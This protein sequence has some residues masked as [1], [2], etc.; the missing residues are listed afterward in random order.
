VRTAEVVADAAVFV[1]ARCLLRMDPHAA[2][3]IGY[4][5]GDRAVLDADT[6]AATV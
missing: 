5:I 6:V 2:N 1:R 3:G 4:A